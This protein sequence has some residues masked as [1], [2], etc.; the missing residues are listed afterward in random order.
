MVEQDR[1][2]LER[3]LNAG[4][5]LQTGEVAVLLELGQKTIDRRIAAG[6]IKTR[7][8]AGSTWRLC[9]PEDVKLLLAD[10]RGAPRPSTGRHAAE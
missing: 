9:D 8:K 1:A 10:M 4:E 3:R 5:W 6:Q 2:E 7:P